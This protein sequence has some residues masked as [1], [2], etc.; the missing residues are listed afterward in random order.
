MAVRGG[1]KREDRDDR[2][3]R[4]HR[5]PQGGGRAGRYKPPDVTRTLR[6]VPTYV[7]SVDVTTEH[8]PA[9]PSHLRSRTTP[10]LPRS[11][12]ED[13]RLES[14]RTGE[15]IRRDDENALALAEQ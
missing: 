5:Y 6:H 9:V 14:I 11:V 4:P 8:G 1:E 15:V 13:S 7:E 10:V 2:H 12:R 3:H